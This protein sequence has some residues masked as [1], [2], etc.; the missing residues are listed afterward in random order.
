MADAPPF[1]ATEP[2]ITCKNAKPFN[3]D[4]A[5]IIVRSV[6]DNVDFRVHKAF[7]SVASPVFRDMFSLPQN[8]AMVAASGFSAAFMKDGLHIVTLDEDQETL[9]TLLRMCYPQWML[10][11][12]DPLLPTIER[13]LAVFEAASK[14]A[15]DGIEQQVR[16][17]L[18]APRF[19][20]PN[21]LRVFAIAVKHRLYEEAKICARYTLRTPVLGKAYKPELEHITAGA[22]HR[23][24]R[25]PRPL[26]G[27]RSARRPGCTLDHERD[28]GLVRVLAL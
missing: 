9:G 2:T 27:G 24:S 8:E 18:V 16:A 14:Y 1:P 22:Y 3:D 20:E 11:D 13:V 15:M 25:I 10:L 5:D 6:P 7:L 4:A 21:P 19:V 28:V 23:P 17:A 26:W 12:C